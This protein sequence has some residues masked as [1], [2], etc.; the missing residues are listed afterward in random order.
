MSAVLNNE[1]KVVLSAVISESQ[2][3]RMIPKMKRECL[4]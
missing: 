1:A 4:Q 3:F 2:V